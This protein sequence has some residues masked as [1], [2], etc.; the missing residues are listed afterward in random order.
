MIVANTGA[1]LQLQALPT[2]TGGL[3]VAVNRPLFLYGSGIA[4]NGALEN[5]YG[6]NTFTGGATT[7]N[8][9][10]TIGVDAGVLTQAGVIGGPGALTKVGG[11]TL[12]QRLDA[13]QRN[14][15]YLG[16][17]NI[18]N[19]VVPAITNNPGNNTSVLGSAA[20]TVTV[21]SGATLQTREHGPS[22][23]WPTSST[24]TAPATRAS[25]SPARRLT[26]ASTGTAHLGTA[27]SS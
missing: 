27:T 4:G 11:G 23:T 15:T 16:G 3:S 20:G 18:N 1:A 26:S 5:V 22:S 14:N 25:T 17:T 7:L 9:S 12:R 8:N 21:S 19:G 10:A 24:S 6:T 13:C 2:G